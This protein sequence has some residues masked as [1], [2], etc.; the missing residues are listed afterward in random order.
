MRRAALFL[1]AM[2]A[3]A[4]AQAATRPAPRV[5]AV[6]HLESKGATA[7]VLEAPDGDRTL[8]VARLGA[9]SAIRLH[10]R[11]LRD[12]V[13]DATG[14]G[15]FLL[16]GEARDVAVA[17]MNLDSNEAP[18]IVVAGLEAAE[19]AL[20]RAGDE[21][22]LVTG[23]AVVAVP[24]SGPGRELLQR[25][26]P[27]VRTVVRNERGT[28][29]A[30][31]HRGTVEL[32]EPASGVLRG[33]LGEGRSP[34]FVDDDTVAFVRDL[35]R[36]ANGVKRVEIVLGDAP[37]GR[38]RPGSALEVAGDVE[39]LREAGDGALSFTHVAASGERRSWLLHVKAGIARPLD[40]WDEGRLRLAANA[41]RPAPEPPVTAARNGAEPEPETQTS[42]LFLVDGGV[43]MR[44][45]Y[46]ESG[47]DDARHPDEAALL[48]RLLARFLAGVQWPFRKPGAYEPF[49]ASDDEPL[50]PRSTIPHL[51]LDV[52]SRLMHLSTGSVAHYVGGA[53]VYPVFRGGRI[54]FERSVVIRDLEAAAGSA[55]FG[56]LHEVEIR[57]GAY[58]LRIHLLYSHVRPARAPGP[59]SGPVAVTGDEPLGVLDAYNDE[60]PA[61][62]W[63]TS[64][65][66]LLQAGIGKGNHVHL[67]TGGIYASF[68]GPVE[69]AQK[70]L[71]WCREAFIPALRKA[72]APR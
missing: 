62:G 56:M 60:S 58:V 9:E 46:E 64:A 42:G 55:R 18:R 65:E 66:P 37:S 21:A 33:S 50:R 61:G 53:A 40:P 39:G 30:T 7:W 3:W 69:A 13:L 32:V 10:D 34:A 67:G 29:L 14:R 52:G 1:L 38:L 47:W 59:E 49:F 26:D 45:A 70:K 20:H 11:A 57:E 71:R 41:S 4:P 17:H 5:L 44:T 48:A 35:G 43:E 19:P 36:A 51:G 12:A 24:R 72:P 31:V 28:M 68:N 6:D 54:W 63:R 23:S 8:L 22:L 16:L 27:A 2:A 25:D 15:A